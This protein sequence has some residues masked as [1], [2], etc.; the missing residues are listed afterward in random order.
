[1]TDKSQTWTAV[2]DVVKE[3]KNMISAKKKI[4]W[5]RLEGNRVRAYTSSDKRY[6]N[7]QGKELEWIFSLDAD[8]RD[9]DPIQKWCEENTCGKRTSFDTFIFRNE[10]ELTIFLLRWG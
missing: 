2:A 9:I 8:E 6:E 7:I 1:M 4:Q 10:K 5:E 3:L